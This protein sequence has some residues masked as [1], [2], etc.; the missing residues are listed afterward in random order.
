MSPIVLDFKFNGGHSCLAIFFS[1]LFF[2]CGWERLGTNRTGSMKEPTIQVN[3]RMRAY[4]NLYR[5][6][7]LHLLANQ[8]KY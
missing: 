7:P 5:A 8:L 1:F 3:R 2:F 6:Q 4:E